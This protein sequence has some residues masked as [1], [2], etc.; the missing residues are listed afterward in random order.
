MASHLSSDKY[1]ALTTL[2]TWSCGDYNELCARRWCTS[3]LTR[4]LGHSGDDLVGS[5]AL[6]MLTMTAFGSSDDNGL[7]AANTAGGSLGDGLAR[8]G[9]ADH[10]GGDGAHHLPCLGWGR[11]LMLGQ[12]PNTCTFFS[13][14]K[15]KTI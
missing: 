14:Y 11:Y 10:G 15:R 2:T 6:N 9:H 4:H 13:F 1:N 5:G 12:K 8:L 3:L 7:F